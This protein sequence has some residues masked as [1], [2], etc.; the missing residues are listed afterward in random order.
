[1]KIFLC[2]RPLD[3]QEG[4]LRGLVPKLL[5]AGR[6][7]K[8]VTPMLS[9]VEGDPELIAG[10]NFKIIPVSL[11]SSG[12]D[13]I[14]PEAIATATKFFSSAE[15]GRIF[16]TSAKLLNRV[17]FSGSFRAIDR[18]A[19]VRLASLR[20]FE[21]LV[22]ERPRMI[23]FLSTPHLFGDFLLHEIAKWVGVSALFFQP[24]PICAA[25]IP[26]TSL[27]DRKA[28]SR[29]LRRLGIVGEQIEESAVA[30]IE[31]LLEGTSPSYIQRQQHLGSSARSLTGRLRLIRH[32]FAWL[33]QPRF[34]ESLDFSGSAMSNGLLR[35]ALSVFLSSMLQK[36]LSNEI[37]LLGR[38]PLPSRFA[39]FALHYEPE[40]TSIPE[41]FPIDFQFDAVLKARELLPPDL[42]LV[43]KEHY[44]QGSPSLRGFLG[45]SPISYQ[46]VEG[47][48]NVTLV[49][50]E[51]D[52]TELLENTVCVFTLTGTIAIESV[53]RGIPV[54]YFGVPWWEGM[55]GTLRLHD[56][57]KFRDVSAIRMPSRGNLVKFLKDLVGTEMVAGIAS[58]D[59]H[60]Y[61]LRH[62]DLSPEFWNEVEEALVSQI[63]DLAQDLLS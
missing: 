14:S 11:F 60:D 45:R 21:L 62:G 31:L 36:R 3:L 34:P 44:S 48:P 16:A 57:S 59:P 25:M 32:L 8:V 47:L 7:S 13:K 33:R 9:F 20:I 35:N 37:R 43:V 46:L 22:K 26:R 15:S 2:T 40:R 6:V 38:P 49:G 63:D 54:A 30:K 42:H 5:E 4:Y 61:Q 10:S 39:L 58:E 41:G 51:V 1:M 18:E 23:V 55:P 17:D 27:T 50:P 19:T 29:P 53:G 56:A 24:T 52:A 28:P 12:P